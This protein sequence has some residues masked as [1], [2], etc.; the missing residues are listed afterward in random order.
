[1]LIVKYHICDQAV[2]YYSELALQTRAFIYKDT[3][4]GTYTQEQ[5]LSWKQLE[6]FN[7]FQSGYVRTVYSWEFNHGGVKCCM[8]KAKV[9]PSQKAA[10]NAHEAWIITKKAGDIICS[11]CTCMAG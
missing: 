2:Y 1:M 5:L 6:A 10:S 8:L 4:V 7:Y 9:N 3:T 11:H